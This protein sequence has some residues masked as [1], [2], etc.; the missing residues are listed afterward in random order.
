MDGVIVKISFYP[1]LFSVHFLPNLSLPFKCLPPNTFLFSSTENASSVSC[2]SCIR[3]L[4]KPENES[5]SPSVCLWILGTH[6]T[7]GSGG[8]EARSRRLFTDGWWS[9][10]GSAGRL[11]GL[12]HQVRRPAA[13][14]RQYR[15]GGPMVM[16]RAARAGGRHAAWV[17]HD[18]GPIAHGHHHAGRAGR[19]REH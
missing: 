19:R 5:Q 18:G 7:I 12:G 13:D 15:A 10:V 6:C 11:D 8:G 4:Q 16:G 9:G 2:T 14:G 3:P 17:R 1:Y